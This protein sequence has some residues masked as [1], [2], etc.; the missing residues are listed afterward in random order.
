MQL[1]GD[2]RLA[3]ALEG[4]P[5]GFADDDLEHGGERDPLQPGDLWRDGGGVADGAG[6]DSRLAAGQLQQQPADGRADGGQVAELAAPEL[7]RDAGDPGD[8]LKDEVAD[9]SRRSRGGRP[10]AD[11]VNQP[12]LDL[13]L[14]IGDK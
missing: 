2:L 9:G 6:Q 11:Q 4:A 14:A 12:V 8:G 10:G 5:A 1:V 13:L 7:R 3:L